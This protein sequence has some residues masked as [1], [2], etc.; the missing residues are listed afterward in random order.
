[1]SKRTRPTPSPSVLRPGYAAEF[2]P[3]YS[4]IRSDLRRIAFLAGGFVVILI[5]ASFFVR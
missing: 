4:H 1:M 3:D 2:D 5:V